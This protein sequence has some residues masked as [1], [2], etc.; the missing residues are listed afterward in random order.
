MAAQRVEPGPAIGAW[1][2]EGGS[3]AIV[4]PGSAFSV[5]PSRLHAD[6]SDPGA[7][8]KPKAA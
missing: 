8:Q 6:L 5:A 1:E 4:V 2:N 7:G 3:L